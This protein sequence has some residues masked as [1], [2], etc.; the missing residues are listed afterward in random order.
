MPAAVA[1][2][3]A[4]LELMQAGEDEW[5]Q[6]DTARK[7]N[8]DYYDGRYPESITPYKHPSTGKLVDNNVSLNLLAMRLDR[9]RDFLFCG[10]PKIALQGGS[11]TD[12]V[13]GATI[14]SDD[15]QWLDDAW[16]AN[17]G[18]IFMGNSVL[19]GGLAGHNY[20]RIMELE[21]G[22]EFPGLRLL[23]NVVTYWQYDDW[24]RVLWHSLYYN[25]GK[26]T[27]RQDVIAPGQAGSAW[28]IITYQKT[29]ANTGMRA[30]WQAVGEPY[31]WPY[32]L[33]PIV[34]WQHWPVSD[35]YYGKSETGDIRGVL[36]VNRLMSL[37]SSILRA[38][39]APRVVITG[40]EA[41]KLQ[42]TAVEGIFT[43][44]KAATLQVLEMQSDLGALM[45]M[46][47]ALIDGYMSQGRTVL[48]K[49]G[50]AD[51][52]SL[53]NL[54]IKVSFMDMSKANEILQH[55]YGYGIVEISRRMRMVAGQQDFLERP[56]LT[57]PEP[58]PES[59]LE[60]VQV[61][62]QERD[63]KIISR[64]GAQIKMEIDPATENARMEREGERD[65]ADINALLSAAGGNPFG[66]PNMQ[67]N[68]G[69]MG[70]MQ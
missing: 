30:Q 7:T 44:P 25:V 35:A 16:E 33:G 28:T 47:Q 51:F 41:G 66:Q 43:I 45:N 52:N 17:Y 37:G 31:I 4:D 20:V 10:W 23:H 8:R 63:M 57:W 40:A 32:P 60:K 69:N 9:R 54:A 22:E 50:P 21:D 39:A 34:D 68:A 36:A 64:E 15:Q 3:P 46:T 61:V 26:V 27:F 13:T 18:P 49:G 58:L 29:G 38:H 65:A 56:M 11:E 48:L 2:D 55:Q 14:I 59:E 5:S 70:N 19:T 67:G 6:R 53:T 12:P 62:R 24:R 1:Y 42:Q